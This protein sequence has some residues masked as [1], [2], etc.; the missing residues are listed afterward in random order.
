MVKHAI[1]LGVNFF[2]TANV[3]SSSALASQPGRFLWH[4]VGF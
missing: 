2:D 1:D 3:Y 4:I